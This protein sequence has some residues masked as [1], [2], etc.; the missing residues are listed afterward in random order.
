MLYLALCVISRL[1]FQL[2]ADN[3]PCLLGLGLGEF[4]AYDSFPWASLLVY[5]QAF[6]FRLEDL[7]HIFVVKERLRV[8][9][10]LPQF[11]KNI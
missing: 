5:N 4:R 10:L 3:D 2:I 8:L 6:R 7:A 9:I 1:I 11:P